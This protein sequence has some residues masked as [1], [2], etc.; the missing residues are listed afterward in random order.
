MRKYVVLI[1]VN[2][3]LATLQLSFFSKLLGNGYAPDLILAFA[4][5]FAFLD[6]N[7][8]AY[9]SAFAGG[10]FLDLLGF[11]IVGSSSVLYV[12]SVVLFLVV[13]KFIS[14]GMLVKIL[15]F[16]VFSYFLSTIRSDVNILVQIFGS[17]LSLFFAFLFYSVLQ[18]LVVYFKKTGYNI[19]RI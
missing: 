7:E 8:E 14:K 19:N 5:A 13:Q 2:I 6:M 15:G 12:G 4:F 1:F 9:F 17:C 16:L 11:N 10:L 3:L 18:N